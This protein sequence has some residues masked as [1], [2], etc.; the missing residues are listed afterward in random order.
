MGGSN[1]G[2]TGQDIV[3]ESS[4][5]DP[6]KSF[7]FVSVEDLDWGSRLFTVK[8]NG[9]TYTF[10]PASKQSYDRSKGYNFDASS[11]PSIAGKGKN[12]L[13]SGGGVGFAITRPELAKGSSPLDPADVISPNAATDQPLPRVP[14]NPVTG[15]Y[16]GGAA[17]RTLSQ[18]ARRGRAAG[19]KKPLLTGY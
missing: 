12:L 15:S 18:S 16:A 3:A 1:N 6:K 9:L 11:P 19:I 14:I 4:P 5:F 7:D 17:S 8:Q 2:K 13:F 10:R